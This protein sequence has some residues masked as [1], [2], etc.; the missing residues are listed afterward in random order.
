MEKKYWKWLYILTACF[1]L[2]WC[3]TVFAA[4]HIHDTTLTL[5]TCGLGVAYA[6]IIAFAVVSMILLRLRKHLYA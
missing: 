6:A 3:G 4:I 2:M 1:I 5:T